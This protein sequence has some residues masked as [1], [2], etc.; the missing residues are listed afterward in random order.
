MGNPGENPFEHLEPL[1]PAGN[2]HRHAPL[3][4]EDR[5]GRNVGNR[6]PDLLPGPL[7]A[8]GGTRVEFEDVLDPENPY[9]AQSI[10]LI[11]VGD[12]HSQPSSCG[13]QRCR[14]SS[15]A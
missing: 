6:R 2:H 15:M 9:R 5:A 7:D 8:I 12:A 13:P 4:L 11:G 3:H 10:R 1:I 14:G